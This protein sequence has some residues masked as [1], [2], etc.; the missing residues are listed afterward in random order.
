MRSQ[1]TR[2]GQMAATKRAGVFIA[3]AALV[4]GGWGGAT[5]RADTAAAPSSGGE[6][7]TV[8]IVTSTSGP[9]S[10]Y[11]QPYLDGLE[12]GLDYATEG[13]RSVDGREIVFEVI[14]DGGE[15]ERAISAATELIG[16]GVTIIAGTGSSGVAIQMAPFAEEN[17]I[18]YISGAAAT[19][20][21]TG[22]N[23]NTF[24]AGRQTYQD[25]AAAAQLLDSVEGADV[26]VFAQ[27]SAFGE[28]NVAAVEAV[29]G[30]A[31]AN[32]E[33]LLVPTTTT[34]FTP[35]AQQII[36]AAPDLLF[37]AWAGETTAAMWQALTQQ[38]VFEATVVTTGLGDVAS[39]AA[40]GS[41]PTGIEFL[42]HYAPG[43]VDNPVNVAMAD[44]VEHHDI[45]TPDGFVTAQMIVQALD[46][47]A[48]DDVDGMIAGLEGWSFDAPKGAQEI[49]AS[50]HAMIQPMFTVT[51]EGEPGSYSPVLLE[52]ID[53]A[54]VAPPEQ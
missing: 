12:A 40:Y 1:H 34:E 26:M 38:G 54:T 33:S 6:P 48:P 49:R 30:G 51:L 32:V 37:V 47:A 13:T 10:V 3:A 15:P 43:I 36:D 41:D 16:N 5:A 4:A 46:S 45:F 11:I 14:D 19:D 35:N 31:G 2:S 44:A 18:L 28:G 21:I 22:I 50:D 52:T 9:L 20:A 23:R 27:D 42:T 8:G 24:R 7:I 53:A 29:L 17:D 25:V 39:Y